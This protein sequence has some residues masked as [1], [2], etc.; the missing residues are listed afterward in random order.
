MDQLGG[1]IHRMILDIF[2]LL[3]DHGVGI[4]LIGVL[5]VGNAMFIARDW[6]RIRTL[7]TRVETLE[8]EYHELST[9]MLIGYEST[10][11]AATRAL[12][13]SNSIFQKILVD[14]A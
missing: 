14:R 9:K 3:S 6:G 13:T 1:E 7:E 10:V 11:R 2:Q 12:D 4:A 8:K 5:L